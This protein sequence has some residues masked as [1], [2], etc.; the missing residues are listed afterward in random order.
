MTQQET[1]AKTITESHS[2]IHDL[3]LASS[4][5]ARFCTVRMSILFPLIGIRLI[6]KYVK[7]P[8]KG[9]KAKTGT[10]KYGFNWVSL[11]EVRRFV[12]CHHAELMENF[13]SAKDDF[14]SIL[15]LS[16]LLRRRAK[17]I[18]LSILL[19]NSA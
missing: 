5:S 3:L 12:S 10:T 8:T 16:L 11:C 19:E 7:Y 6:G 13:N 18:Q 4:S 17:F 14:P 1:P 9:I 15:Y 2:C